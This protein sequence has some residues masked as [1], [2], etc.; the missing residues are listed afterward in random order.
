MNKIIGVLIVVGLIAAAYVN[1]EKIAAWRSGATDE[2]TQPAVEVAPPGS[3]TPH[4]G[5]ASQALARKLYPGLAIAGSAMNKK[6][7]ALH[8]EAKAT[9]PDLLA[10]PDWPIILAERAMVAMGGVP[11]PRAT[12]VPITPKPL[13]GS[14]LDRKPSAPR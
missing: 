1:R 13:Q 11:L 5:T 2:A 4:P 6:F 7:L 14:L 8:A 3:R 9:E 10:S 12:P